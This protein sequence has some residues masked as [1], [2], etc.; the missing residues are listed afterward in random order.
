[1]V[2]LYVIKLHT[3]LFKHCP[4]TDMQSCDEAARKILN[5]EICKIHISILTT[6]A[7][8]YFKDWLSKF[9]RPTGVHYNHCVS[10]TIRSFAFHTF[11]GT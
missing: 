7:G 8:Q 9:A 2:H 11:A 5:V 4:A 10:P 1:M 3:F 6:I